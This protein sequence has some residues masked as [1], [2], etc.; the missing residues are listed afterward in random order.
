MCCIAP[1]GHSARCRTS[2]VSLQ[3]HATVVTSNGVPI[4]G[5]QFPPTVSKHC[6]LHHS[7]IPI[8][9]TAM[10]NVNNPSSCDV[11]WAASSGQHHGSFV[12]SHIS[13]FSDVYPGLQTYSKHNVTQFTVYSIWPLAGNLFILLPDYIKNGF[14]AKITTGTHTWRY[15]YLLSALIRPWK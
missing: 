15:I 9:I 1:G 8:T 4:C 7:A 3:H 10:W 2:W 6:R 11:Q 14:V 13:L 5:S 12:H